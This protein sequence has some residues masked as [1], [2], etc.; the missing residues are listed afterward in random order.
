MVEKEH[1]ERGIV[2]GN[3]HSEL[4]ETDSEWSSKAPASFC[5]R[6]KTVSSGPLTATAAMLTTMHPPYILD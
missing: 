4:E 5:F 1:D 2:E 6:P 3:E